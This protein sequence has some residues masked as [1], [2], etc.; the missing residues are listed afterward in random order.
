[1]EPR[2]KTR[3]PLVTH[4]HFSAPKE[5]KVNGSDGLD[6]EAWP[7]DL[8]RS[9]PVLRRTSFLGRTRQ[10]GAVHVPNFQG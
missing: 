4:A 1:M 5:L 6:E 3:A 8:G 7:A 10:N 2:T 9:L